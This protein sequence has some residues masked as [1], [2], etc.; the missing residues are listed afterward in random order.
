MPIQL[1][2]E[3][4]GKFLT[5]HVTGHLVRADY[6]IF[7]PVCERLIRQHGKLRVLF[8]MTGLQGWDAGAAPLGKTSNSISNTSP[9]DIERLA[10]VGENKLQHGMAAFFKPFTKA[11]TRY[12]DHNQMDAAQKWLTES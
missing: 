1:N 9:T 4:D 8:D 3:H 10:M 6:D 2:E 5:I 11:T 7:V 12:F